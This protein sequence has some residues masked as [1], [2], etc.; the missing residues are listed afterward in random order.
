V[1]NLFWLTTLI[2]G[3][4]LMQIF[5]PRDARRGLLPTITWS[6]V[7]TVA[8]LA[9]V[10]MFAFAVHLSSRTVAIVYL[11]LVLAGAIAAVR[12]DGLRTVGR[13]LRTTHWFEVALVLLAVALTYPLGAAA[14][15]DAMAHS[16]KIRYIRD[17]GFSLQDAYS[18]LDVIET[19]W[20]VNAH[21]LYFVVASWI[22][23]VE[24]LD[25]FVKSSWFF[26]LLALGAIGFLAAAVFRSRWIST[27]AMLGAVAVM[28][29]KLTIV[30]PFSVTGFI[31]VPV[32]LAVVL[33]VLERPTLRQYAR[34]LLGSMSLAVLHVGTWFLATLCIGPVVAIWA[35]WR[36]PLQ[37]AWRPLALAAATLVTGIPLLLV[38]ALQ[39][40]YVVAHQDALHVRFIR[41]IHLGDWSIT[42]I[43]PMQYAWMLPVLSSLLLLAIV[44][45]GLRRRIVL[46]AGIII[47]GML[48]MFVP[49]FYD[50]VVSLVPYWLL[51]RL[52]GFAEVIGFAV[53]A[54][55][56]AWLA[57]PLLTTRRARQAMALVVL[58]G[59][60]AVFR[61]NIL[62]YVLE[63]RSQRQWLRDAHT[64]QEA[65]ASAIEPHSL[66]A[67][68]PVWS[69]VLPSVHLTRVMAADLH[70]AN[71]SDGGLLERYADTQELLAPGTPDDRRRAIVAKHGID[72][73]VVR[74]PDGDV[75]PPRFDAVGEVIRERHGFVVYRTRN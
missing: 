73:I 10:V 58:C 67:A 7:L 13:L 3:F 64:F 51:V 54:G 26:R 48:F 75:S 16:A 27:V 35:L 25:L 37:Q 20:H 56:L 9:P 42:I 22:S 15:S 19:K 14:E 60:L 46:L 44:S 2:P 24:P 57:R 45:A 59:S 28:C 68:D 66:V 39:P 5:W 17:V 32:L 50:A 70:H 30:F 49:G 63:T 21:H 6:Y 8:L 47:A 38:S 31:I 18:P 23:G 34:V 69:L 36:R 72:Y 62:G 61:E 55:G 4:A 41:T 52:R 40:N 71:P 29:T 1:V 65:V 53:I 12:Y 33:D 74:D 43:D 11:A